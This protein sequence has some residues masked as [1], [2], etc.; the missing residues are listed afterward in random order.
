MSI[1]KH[2]DVASRAAWLHT[3]HGIAVDD[4]ALSKQLNTLQSS[5]VLVQQEG[6]DKLGDHPRISSP[7]RQ[8]RKRCECRKL[9]F[10]PGAVDEFPKLS[11]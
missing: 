5:T 8:R 4:N 2:L 1:L 10:P 3:F 11:E 7:K 9:L 6:L